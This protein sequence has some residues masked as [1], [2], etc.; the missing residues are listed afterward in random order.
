MTESTN[1]P[2]TAE[3]EYIAKNRD[4]APRDYPLTGGGTLYLPARSKNTAWPRI[5]ESQI[6]APLRTAQT[7]GHITL[8]KVEPKEA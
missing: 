8:I 3:T 7:R 6:S 2:K 5:K 4:T 1:P